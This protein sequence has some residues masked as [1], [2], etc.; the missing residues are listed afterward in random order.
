VGSIPIVSTMTREEL[1]QYVAYVKTRCNKLWE[2]CI[3][4]E[5]KDHTGLHKCASKNCKTSWTDE[6]SKEYMDSFKSK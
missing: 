4:D 6:Q 1:D 2:G 5:P 3:C